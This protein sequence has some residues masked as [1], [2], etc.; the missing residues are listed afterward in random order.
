MFNSQNN[1]SING[2]NIENLLN[3]LMGNPCF[4][5]YENKHLTGQNKFF[6]NSSDDYWKNI[7]IPIHKSTKKVY[8][9]DCSFN[10]YLFNL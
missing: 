6:S 9:I 1:L 8:P 7:E 3:N 2:A 5:N 4:L 10:N